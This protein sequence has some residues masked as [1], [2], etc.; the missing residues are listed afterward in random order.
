MRRSWPTLLALVLLGLFW[1]SYGLLGVL[2]AFRLAGVE[3]SPTAFLLADLEWT[4]RFTGFGIAH[5]LA[6][7]GIANWRGWAILLAAVLALLG[8]LAL[9]SAALSVITMTADAEGQFDIPNVSVWR[10]NGWQVIGIFGLLV[11][12]DVVVLVSVARVGLRRLWALVAS[13]NGSADRRIR[14]PRLRSRTR[15]PASCGQPVRA[16]RCCSITCSI[17]GG[18]WATFDPRPSG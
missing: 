1:F 15:D 5:L 8:L 16:D 2:N 17:R 6:G 11:L 7:Y 18:L 14:S 3:R 10:F 13:D 12:A 4:A 9:G